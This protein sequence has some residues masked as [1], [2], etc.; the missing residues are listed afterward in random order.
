M[1]RNLR[2]LRN[3]WDKKQYNGT[4]IFL[5]R[6]TGIIKCLVIIRLQEVSIFEGKFEGTTRSKQRTGISGNV[7]LLECH[8]TKMKRLNNLI[9]SIIY[10]QISLNGFLL[11]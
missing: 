5:F 2:H 8:L 11:R 4:T 7:I 10:I 9:I 1:K 3:L 6:L